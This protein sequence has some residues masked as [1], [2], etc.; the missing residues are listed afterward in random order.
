MARLVLLN[1]DRETLVA[2]LRAHPQWTLAQL[3]ELDG[4]SS[5]ELLQ[6]VRVCDLW[7]VDPTRLALAQR[8]SGTAFDACV[9]A[10]IR[11]AGFVVNAGYLRARVG[12]PRWKLQPALGRLCEAGAIERSGTTGSTRYRLAESQDTNAAGAT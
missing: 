8:L 2:V 11:E 7:N 3:A 10:V 4:T 12:G 9:L 6:R 5:G 1:P